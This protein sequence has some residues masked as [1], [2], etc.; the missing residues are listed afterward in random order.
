MKTFMNLLN[1]K[2]VKSIHVQMYLL[3]G[4]RKT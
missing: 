4:H 1:R 2:T 3:N